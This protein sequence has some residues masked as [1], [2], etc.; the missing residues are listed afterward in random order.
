MSSLLYL[1]L[2]GG[3]AGDMIL[4]ALL[5][6]GADL[7]AVQ[8]AVDGLIEGVRFETHEA[9]PAGLRASRL[10]V[11]VR[12]RLGDDHEHPHSHRPD[13]APHSHSHQ[14]RP[15]RWIR[16][17]LS[18]SSLGPRAKAVALDTFRRLAAAEGHVHGVAP[19]DVTFHEVGS[20]DAIA[21]V[22][23]VAVAI[24]AL[25]PSS[26]VCSP[27]PLGRGLTQGAHGPIPLPG[28]ATLELLIGAPVRQTELIG[29]TVTPTGAALIRALAERFGP[30]PDMTLEKV[31]VGAGHRDWPD[32]PNVVRAVLG[33]ADARGGF[34]TDEE[35]LVETNIDDMTAAHLSALEDAVFAS[36]A[37]DVWMAPVH[38]K[39]GRP[40]VVVSALVPKTMLD[41]VT[42]ALMTHSTTLGIRVSEVARIRG[43]RHVEEVDTEYGR[44]RI[45]VAERPVGPHL[46]MPEFDDCERLAKAAGVPVRAVSEAAQRAFWTRRV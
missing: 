4:A 41:A 27:L 3:A 1:D 9:H 30:I 35:L 39:K 12:G 32:R 24:E 42:L 17:K 22:V 15:Y 37:L 10:D 29:E 38:M 31:G 40:G 8:R 2:V 26:I 14:H 16:D 21:D 13:H 34:R 5:D 45:K 43:E 44:V 6:L 25:A 46:A 18:A 23:G 11:T 36:G 28:P 19:D 7:A 20:D 33:R